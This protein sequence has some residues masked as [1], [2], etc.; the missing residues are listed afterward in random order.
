MAV[1]QPVGYEIR[2]GLQHGRGMQVV[3]RGDRTDLARNFGG[4]DPLAAPDRR[5]MFGL[6]IAVTRIP[7]GGNSDVYGHEESSF[8]F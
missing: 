4:L 3:H 8:F 6:R 7:S 2:Q 5:I 1:D